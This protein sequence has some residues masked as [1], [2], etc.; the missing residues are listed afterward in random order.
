ML[1]KPATVDR[2]HRDG[3]TSM[4]APPLT[5]PWTTTDLIPA[6][7]D[8][9]RRMVAENCLWGAPRIHGELLEARNHRFG[10]QRLAGTA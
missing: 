1:I 3:Y 2:W 6:C 5:A 8:L 7:R 10:T 9:I 4:L